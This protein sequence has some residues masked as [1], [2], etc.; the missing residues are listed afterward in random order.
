M[1][2]TDELIIAF[3]TIASAM[4]SRLFMVLALGAE[5]NGAYA[6]APFEE[7]RAVISRRVSSLAQKKIEGCK[8]VETASVAAQTPAIAA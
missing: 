6:R 2:L 1:T 3:P 4:S 7:T 5:K 8:S